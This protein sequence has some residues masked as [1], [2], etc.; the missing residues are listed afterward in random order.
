VDLPDATAC[1]HHCRLRGRSIPDRS[2]FA[3]LADL[4]KKIAPPVR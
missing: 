3:C 2:D 1:R 4:I